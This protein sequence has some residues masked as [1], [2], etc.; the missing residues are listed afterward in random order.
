MFI[1]KYE[2]SCHN[3][4]ILHGVHETNI[5]EQGMLIVKTKSTKGRVVGRVGGDHCIG[6]GIINIVSSSQGGVN[7]CVRKTG[8]MKSQDSVLRG[9]RRLRIRRVVVTVPSTARGRVGKVLSVYGRAKY[10]LGHLPNVCRLMGNSIDIDG[11]GS[12]SI[13]S[14]LKQSPIAI[15]LRS[16][17]SCISKGVVVIAK[18]NN[19]VKDRLYQR[20]TTRGPGRL[21]V[22]SVC[23]GAACSIRGRLGIQF[24]SLSLII[25]VTS[26]QGAGHVG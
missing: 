13:G 23:R 6:G 16:V 8:I 3:L 7:G 19:S 10:A 15:S 4:H 25:L 18:N 2:C 24:P 11:L 5:C 17:V 22:I 20:V 1:V 14:L 9:I 12:M 26:I 21:V